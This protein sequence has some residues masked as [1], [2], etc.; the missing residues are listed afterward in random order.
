MKS[1]EGKLISNPSYIAKYA[2]QQSKQQIQAFDKKCISW[3]KQGNRKELHRQM[4]IL[5]QAIKKNGKK[6]NLVNKVSFA[7][8]TKAF[9]A[10]I[11]AVLDNIA[12]T[13]YL[14]QSRKALDDFNKTVKD[15][16]SSTKYFC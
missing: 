3:Q 8:A 10:P 4:Q 13:P 11:T 7:L 14:S 2:D 16:S 6:E 5:Q 1:A 15:L 12:H 9:T